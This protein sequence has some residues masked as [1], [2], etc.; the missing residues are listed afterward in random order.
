[1]KAFLDKIEIDC[2][3]IDGRVF[4]PLFIMFNYSKKPFFG[5]GI[6]KLKSRL[7]YTQNVWTGDKNNNERVN[8][9][10]ENLS[11]INE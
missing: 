4:V 10:G 5:S 6:V 11:K 2:K 7:S 9:P 8:L 3:S 1:M